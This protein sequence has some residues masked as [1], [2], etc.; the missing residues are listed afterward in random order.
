[1]LDPPTFSDFP[2]PQ[3]RV[4]VVPS[5]PK[6]IVFPMSNWAP[7]LVV[8]GAGVEE[9][10]EPVDGTV[11]LFFEPQPAIPNTAIAESATP[12]A[13]A[14][15]REVPQVLRIGLIPLRD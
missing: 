15:Q 13:T 3:S 1:L 12:A 10:G 2:S 5:D 9:A 11:L 8:D 4:V 14:R 6:L 7:V